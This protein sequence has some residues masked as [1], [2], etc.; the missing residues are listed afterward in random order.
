MFDHSFDLFASLFPLLFALV[1]GV[2]LFSVIKSLV[3]WQKNNNSPV[4]SELARVVSKRA[5]THHSSHVDANGLN[6]GSNHTSYYITFET[7]SGIRIE[8]PVRGKQY[9]LLI[10]QDTGTLTYQGTRYI[11]FE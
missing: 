5:D 6:H 10:E 7:Q 4:I 3:Q 11:D 8:L 9:G 2:M 1:G